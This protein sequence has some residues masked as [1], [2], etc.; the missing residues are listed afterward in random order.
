M[1]A[2]SAEAIAQQNEWM[3]QLGGTA[4]ELQ[5]VADQACR[6]HESYLAALRR[7][8]ELYAYCGKLMVRANTPSLAIPHPVEAATEAR[9]VVAQ[10]KLSVDQW[11]ES[12]D[13]LALRSFL[14]NQ[15]E[16]WQ[17]WDNEVKRAFV[18]LK[19][20][21]G[22]C[23]IID[24]VRKNIKR[25]GKLNSSMA[26][27]LRR[28][29]SQLEAARSETDMKVQRD[30]E[31]NAKLCS[32]DLI[33]F[34][35]TFIDLMSKSGQVCAVSFQ[36]IGFDDVASTTTTSS[37]RRTGSSTASVRQVPT[38]TVLGVV[39]HRPSPRDTV[40]ES[41]EALD[42]ISYTRSFT[43]LREGSTVGSPTLTAGGS[44]V[45]RDPTT[46]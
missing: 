31:E 30:I 2:L 46:A 25:T 28:Q 37:S 17:M 40:E 19:R 35:T 5:S 20:R 41:T 4:A 39:L 11:R 6:H 7:M 15:K 42:G 44:S 26:E 8:S 23:R 16:Q 13:E 29:L 43:Y 27:E 38:T 1:P 22:E 12:S 14:Q 9:R 3:A 36:P 45:Y 10:L 21:Q 34:G 24:E 33:K 18:H 32:R